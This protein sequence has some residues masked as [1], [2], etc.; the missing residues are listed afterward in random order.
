MS[1]YTLTFGNPLSSFLLK[2]IFLRDSKWSD[3]ITGETAERRVAQLSTR[4]SFK[5]TF[6]CCLCLRR[7]QD[8]RL[9]ELGLKRAMKELEVDKFIKSQMRLKVALKAIFTKV[10]LF[11]IKNNRSF[12]LNKGSE[13][14]ADEAS[15]DE[16]S[17]DLKDLLYGINGNQPYL[18]S[19]LAGAVSKPNPPQK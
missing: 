18:T 11:L 16:K 1:L 4:K 7:K 10:E 14:K 15:S 17:N 12:L 8:R 6:R 3:S 5:S 19:L 2:S 13:N 9:G